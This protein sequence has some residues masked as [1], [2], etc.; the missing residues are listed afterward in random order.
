MSC[1][2]MI[3]R[4]LH[5]IVNTYRDRQKRCAEVPT[6]HTQYSICDRADEMYTWLWSWRSG[7]IGQLVSLSSKWCNY[8]IIYVLYSLYPNNIC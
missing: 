7:V 6:Q 4:Q 5:L 8:Q 1:G 3:P 2:M